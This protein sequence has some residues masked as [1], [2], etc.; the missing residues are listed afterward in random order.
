VRGAIA[1]TGT[2]AVDPPE[3]RARLLAHIPAPGQVTTRYNGRYASRWN[4]PFR[5]PVVS[6][7]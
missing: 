1:T 7:S 5:H 3:F 2:Q 6:R 4:I